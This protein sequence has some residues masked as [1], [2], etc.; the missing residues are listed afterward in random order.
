MWPFW[1]VNIFDFWSGNRVKQCNK[2]RGL[3]DAFDFYYRQCFNYEHKRRQSKS[4]KIERANGRIIKFETEFWH[5]IYRIA[6]NC[7][8]IIKLIQ[9]Y[10]IVF[11][12]LKL[13]QYWATEHP[14]RTTAAFCSCNVAISAWY[15]VQWEKS[16]RLF[17]SFTFLRR[18][19]HQELIKFNGFSVCL[20]SSKV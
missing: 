11:N 2:Q 4:K 7:S 19:V 16:Q 17:L 18:Y 15:L 6:F 3:H 1:N 8:K 12:T 10:R 14:C 9:A 20:F 13:F 5:Y